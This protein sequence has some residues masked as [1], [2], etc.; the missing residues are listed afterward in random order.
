MTSLHIRPAQ[1]QDMPVIRALIKDAFAPTP[2][3]DG[4]EYLLID[5]LEAAGALTLSL[6]ATDADGAICGHIAFSPVEISDQS[7][8]WYG[9]GPLAVAPGLQK[10]GIGGA[11]V[12][13]GLSRLKAM[14]ANGCVV[15]GSPDYYGRFGFKA[16]QG[17][18][19]PGFP[20]EH[21]MALCLHA[22]RAPSGRLAYNPA[23]S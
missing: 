10:S 15:L 16:R 3:S 9:L 23:F 19:L 17:L 1:S 22:P 2:F 5:K 6:V 11:L 18:E 12:R 14:G 7:R 21:F 13:D 20:A 8:A 4:T